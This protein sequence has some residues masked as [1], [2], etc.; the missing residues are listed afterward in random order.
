MIFTII[1]TFLYPKKVLQG[2]WRTLER[3]HRALRISW[4]TVRRMWL[5]SRRS[6]PRSH[7]LPVKGSWADFGRRLETKGSTEAQQPSG[8]SRVQVVSDVGLHGESMALE[9]E[10]HSSTSS[11]LDGDS[12]YREHC[13]CVT[14][15]CKRFCSCSSINIYVTEKKKQ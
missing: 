4:R 3:E 10:L 9:L 5:V 13:G 7:A 12:R 11:V 1:S 15:W 14:C 2:F 8:T 6:R